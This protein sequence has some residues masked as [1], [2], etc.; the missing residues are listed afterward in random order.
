MGEWCTE[1]L[2]EVLQLMLQA[3]MDV[4]KAKEN[5]VSRLIDDVLS[6]FDM[7]VSLLSASGSSDSGVIVER[8]SQCLILMLQLYATCQNHQ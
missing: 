5:E 4:V 1:I 7:C 6:C 3:L 8:A 2:L